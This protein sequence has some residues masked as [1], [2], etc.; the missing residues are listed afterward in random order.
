MPIPVVQDAVLTM[1]IRALVQLA[2]AMAKLFHQRMEPMRM[3]VRQPLI[4]AA[5]EWAWVLVSALAAG[6]QAQ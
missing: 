1:K 6:S 2:R 3:A 5:L 4:P